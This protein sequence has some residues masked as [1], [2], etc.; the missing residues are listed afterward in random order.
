MT[1]KNRKKIQKFHVLKCC[2]CS[3]LRAAS[4]V[5]AWPSF[6]EAQGQVAC[7]FWS[8]T[9]Y[10]YSAEIFFNFCSS[11]PW[12]RTGIQRKLLDPDP[13]QMNTDPKH[14]PVTPPPR[15]HPP[16][17][18]C[19]MAAHGW[20]GQGKILDGSCRLPYLFLLFFFHAVPQAAPSLLGF[21]NP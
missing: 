15:P 12:I 3:L 2:S 13:Q 5:A 14:C 8:K 11:K 10:F 16:P 18:C 7:G 17:A 1:H 6:M 19:C 21:Y 20:F 9:S 4:S